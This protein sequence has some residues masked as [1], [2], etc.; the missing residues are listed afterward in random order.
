MILYH[1]EIK[2]KKEFLLRQIDQLKQNYY[3]NDRIKNEKSS[4]NFS[5]EKQNGYIEKEISDNNR[6]LDVLEM[7]ADNLEKEIR[8]KEDILYKENNEK[9]NTNQ[10]NSV[11]EKRIITIKETIKFNENKIYSIKKEIDNIKENINK[12]NLE[13]DTYSGR[14]DELINELIVVNKKNLKVK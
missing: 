6:K 4:I 1:D 13:K 3:N 10:F 5:T 12:I 9:I 7:R 8:I 11:L 2:Q 14:I